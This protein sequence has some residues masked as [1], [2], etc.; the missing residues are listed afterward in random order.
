[1]SACHG[2]YKHQFLLEEYDAVRMECDGY[3]YLTQTVCFSTDI[4]LSLHSTVN[5]CLK[6]RF[7]TFCSRNILLAIWI[8]NVTVSGRSPEVAQAPVRTRGT[9]HWALSP[10]SPARRRC[11]S[12]PSPAARSHGPPG[13]GGGRPWRLRPPGRSLAPLGAAGTSSLSNKGA[14]A[15]LSAQR[16]EATERHGEGNREIL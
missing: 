4:L 11:P 13:A 16:A 1:M 5:Q 9:E 6:F 10:L 8:L 12:R 3:L 2:L 15:G 14:P 7:Q